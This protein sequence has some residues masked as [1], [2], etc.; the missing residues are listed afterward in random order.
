MSEENPSIE[1]L[2]VNIERAFEHI[3]KQEETLSLRHNFDLLIKTLVDKGVI[4]AASAHRAA[5]VVQTKNS[6]N[7]V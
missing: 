6:E 3:Q 1:V 7:F 2:L 4:D 5:R